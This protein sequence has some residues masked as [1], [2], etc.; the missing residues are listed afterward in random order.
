MHL[1]SFPCCSQQIPPVERVEGEGSLLCQTPCEGQRDPGRGWTT[2]GQRHR[3]H[4][5]AWDELGNLEMLCAGFCGT[6]AVPEQASPRV[7]GIV[8]QCPHGHPNT[9]DLL[10]A[11]FCQQAP[12]PALRPQGWTSYPSMPRDAL[13][14]AQPASQDLGL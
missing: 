1:A 7:P 11:L 12:N 14:D 3:D 10:P 9:C 4:S 8:T 5:S 6:R 13:G 2:L